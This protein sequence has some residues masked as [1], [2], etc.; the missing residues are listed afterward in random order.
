MG[1]EEDAV[2][3]TGIVGGH[4]VAYGKTVAVEG[5]HF[6]CLYVHILGAMTI[7]LVDDV[8][9]TKAVAFGA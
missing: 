7:E 8:L 9:T 1:C 2:F 5:F 6:A 3:D 4:D